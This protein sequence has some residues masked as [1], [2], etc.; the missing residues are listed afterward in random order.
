M[1]TKKYGEWREELQQQLSDW[2]EIDK[3]MSSK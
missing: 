1:F 2:G 3:A